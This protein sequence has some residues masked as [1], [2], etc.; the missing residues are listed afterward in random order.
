[1]E[2][3][4]NCS[5]GI[6]LRDTCHQTKYIRKQGLKNVFKLETK[7]RNFLRSDHVFSPD[8]YICLHHEQLYINKYSNWQ[9]KCCD[10]WQLHKKQYLTNISRP[11]VKSKLMP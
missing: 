5:A 10:P 8:D 2:S 11:Y 3:I 1:M 9:L 6:F 7:A 4:T